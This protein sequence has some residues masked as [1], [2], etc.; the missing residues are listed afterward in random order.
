MIF[1]PPQSGPGLKVKDAL[2]LLVDPTLIGEA[3]SLRKPCFNFEARTLQ[4]AREKRRGETILG[5]R[6]TCLAI[7]IEISDLAI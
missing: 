2:T 1:V 4:S 7:P 3:P 6:V 5:K